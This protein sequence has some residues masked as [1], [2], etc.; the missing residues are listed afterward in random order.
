FRALFNGA[1]FG[2]V[3]FDPLQQLHA[4]LL[5]GHLPAA[6]PQGYLGLVTLV[7]E[8]DKV[9]KLDLIVP[10]FRPWTKLDFLDLNLL[11]ILPRGGL[12]LLLLEDVLAVVHDTADRR[13]CV[14][15][16]FNQVEL[17]LLC[18]GQCF[19]NG[20]DTDLFTFGADQAHFARRDVFVDRRALCGSFVLSHLAFNLYCSEF[21]RPRCATARARNSEN[22]AMVIVPRSLPSRVR[23]ATVCDS[24]S[25]S[26]I[27]SR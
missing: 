9:T 1:V 7:E 15:G 12:L 23:T 5:M 16:D 27:T 22:S 18:G 2:K 14:G 20:H 3:S 6:E 10:F 8:L 17:G 25:R 24:T 19:L 13:F 21:G 11:L 26:P 4:Q